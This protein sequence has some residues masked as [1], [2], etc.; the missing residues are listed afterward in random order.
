MNL[1]Y[2][3]KLNECLLKSS[4]Y[5][6]KFFNVLHLV[7]ISIQC[8]QASLNKIYV[9]MCVYVGCEGWECKREINER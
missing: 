4:Y 3:Y 6:K 2:K 9:F 5:I 1:S 7:M 8:L